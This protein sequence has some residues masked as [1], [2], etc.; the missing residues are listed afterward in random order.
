MIELFG[1][2]YNC[3][4]RGASG[5]APENT[6]AA[7]KLAVALGADMAEIDVQQTADGQLVLFHD[8]TLERTSSGSGPLV[9]CTLTELRAL[10]AGSWF[11]HFCA[12][13]KIPTLIEA[14]SAARGQL[15]LNIELKA[16][17][18]VPGLLDR[19]IATIADQDFGDHCVITSFDHA[20]IDELV[21]REPNFATGYIIG[22]EGL[23]VDVFRA[24]VD[25]LSLEKSLLEEAE[26]EFATA[27]GKAVHVWTVNDTEEMSHLIAHGVGGVITNY[28]DRF[29]ASR[30]RPAG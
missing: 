9:D 1:Q 4:H 5:Y 28:P 14:I 19:L 26:L 15:D 7:L 24:K 23:P 29:P 6:L 8:E 10:D 16:D 12:G 20:L 18:S 30:T 21:A 2:V 25:L 17:G 27:A 11:S 22:R 3:A 13:E